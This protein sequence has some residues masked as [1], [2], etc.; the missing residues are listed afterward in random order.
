MEDKL[1]NKQPKYDKKAAIILLSFLMAVVLSIGG[2]FIYRAVDKNTGKV[3]PYLLS[4]CK[5]KVNN[6]QYLPDVSK[7]ASEGVAQQLNASNNSSVKN[8]LDNLEKNITLENFNDVIELIGG[9]DNP[10]NRDFTIS[11]VKDEVYKV[12]NNSTYF[13]RWMYLQNEDLRGRGIYRVNYNVK[14]EHL[15]IMRKSGFQPGIYLK[16]HGKIL[17]NDDFN[18]KNRDNY[19]FEEDIIYKIDY[20]F[21]DLDREVVECEIVNII[22][23]YEDNL[24]SKY[25]YIKNIK[26]A[27]F[28]KYIIDIT[29]QVKVEEFAGLDIDTK[30][31]LGTARD[32]IQMDYSNKDDVTLLF[33]K[34]GFATAY[35]KLQDVSQ[36]KFY[37]KLDD[38][39][40]LYNA[41]YAY[42][43]MK[44]TPGTNNVGIDLFLNYQLDRYSYINS[45]FDY[46]VNKNSNILYGTEYIGTKPYY[47]DLLLGKYQYDENYKT[48]SS[49]KIEVLNREI[50]CSNE[51]DSIYIEPC[52]VYNKKPTDN[53]N[54]YYNA[55]NLPLYVNQSLTALSKNTKLATDKLNLS[56]SPKYLN[57]SEQDYSY[58]T[59]IDKCLNII[60]KNIIDS[61]YIRLNYNSFK[62]PKTI[63]VED[64]V[65]VISDYI[66]LNNFEG[67]ATINNSA[68]TFNASASVNKTILLKNNGNYSL[69]LVAKGSGNN[70]VMLLSGEQFTYKR[71]TLNLNAT[72]T[73][74]LINLKTTISDSY[75][76]G[77]GLVVKDND[78]YLLCSQVQPL[79]FEN[80]VDFEL[81]EAELNGYKLTYNSYYNNSNVLIVDVLS[82]D[83]EPPKV[84]GSN[85]ITVTDKTTVLEVL[86][87]FLI[88]DNN[89][90]KFVFIKSDSGYY[91]NCFDA[92]KLGNH[93]LIV[94]D[95]N[96]NKTTLNQY[97][98]FS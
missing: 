18:F 30:N 60:T 15:T 22:N 87:N 97:V 31:E 98:N 1:E 67:S 68:L 57:I 48:R 70:F 26:D 84:E 4:L 7:L 35:N 86:D 69:A 13:N 49:D 62:N 78:N 85:E 47:T 12:L 94:Y 66:E 41:N 53:D 42:G 73:C 21:D 64:N 39:F 54:C 50:Y 45:I 92:I 80:K 14:D 6:A 33:V 38:Q 63:D 32:F 90:V 9:I 3:Q 28:T 36:V 27:S 83:F 88:T 10:Y 23:F 51:T 93:S 79:V 8:E 61:S 16:E 77:I 40:Y 95:Y 72:G 2:F 56:D 81:P 52:S 19:P 5:N 34:Q 89:K 44:N 37:K 55:Q 71:D 76:I 29:G 91:F 11:E 17:T 96:N 59:F 65:S 24:V 25:Q 82:K 43:D 46:Y 20:Y 75:V 58:E 74:D